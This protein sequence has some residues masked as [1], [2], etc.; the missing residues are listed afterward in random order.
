MSTTLVYGDSSELIKEVVQFMKSVGID[1]GGENGVM[2]D[3]MQLALLLL[4]QILH[5]TDYI[6]CLK[7]GIEETFQYY[8]INKLCII[9]PKSKLYNSCE[10]LVEHGE[11]TLPTFCVIK[12]NL[13]NDFI[14]GRVRYPLL[15]Y[16]KKSLLDVTPF[17]TG[18]AHKCFW[19]NM[20]DVLPSPHPVVISDKT[21][22]FIKTVSFIKDQIMSI[23]WVNVANDP[24]VLVKEY[25]PNKVKELYEDIDPRL[26]E[27]I[28]NTFSLGKSQ[29]HSQAMSEY[30]NRTIGFTFFTTGITIRNL[31]TRTTLYIPFKPD[32]VD[33]R[34]TV[35]WSEDTVRGGTHRIFGY[36]RTSIN[37]SP[38]IN[39][40][41]DISALSYYASKYAIIGGDNKNR[42]NNTTLMDDTLLFNSEI[43][44]INKGNTSIADDENVVNLLNDYLNVIKSLAFPYYGSGNSGDAGE[45]TP[46]SVYVSITNNCRFI[47]IVSDITISHS[48]AIY[49]KRKGNTDNYKF[50]SFNQVYMNYDISITFNKITTQDFSSDTVAQVGDEWRGGLDTV[51]QD[52]GFG[53]TI[54]I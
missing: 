9:K 7:G 35:V 2:D 30:E 41:L 24:T 31:A 34:Y 49:N 21:W 28:T 16:L 37:S 33:D 40:K 17:P 50:D 44:S 54:I 23:D 10:A 1:I 47:G 53:T 42:I 5:I 13:Y 46:P 8:Q 43:S 25:L 12:E 22:K 4:Q 38:T 26:V 27:S 48:G 32:G 20:E 51:E 39:F 6:D 36:D 15:V 18:Y 52:K 45:L 19:V 11:L 29:S 3:K 14:N